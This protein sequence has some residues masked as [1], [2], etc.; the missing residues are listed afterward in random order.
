MLNDGKLRCGISAILVYSL[1]V[2]LFVRLR[3][4]NQAMKLIIIMSM[5]INNIAQKRWIFA[6]LRMEG[7]TKL[8][9]F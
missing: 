4:L 5:P 2:F 7:K 1:N 8:I 9:F 6:K 3:S